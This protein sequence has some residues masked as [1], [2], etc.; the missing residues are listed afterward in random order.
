[1]ASSSSKKLSEPPLLRCAA[2]AQEL[3]EAV[4]NV[5]LLYQEGANKEIIADLLSQLK[6]TSREAK[7][8]AQRLT[9]MQTLNEHKAGKYLILDGDTI[10][11]ATPDEIIRQV[12]HYPPKGTPILAL[13]NAA[14]Q[15]PRII[16]HVF[17][18]ENA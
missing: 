9:R 15:D 11:P 14:K 6:A 12:M 7:Q 8:I 3:A 1:M 2:I 17:R 4:D 18:E 10:R 13:L 5:S 16:K